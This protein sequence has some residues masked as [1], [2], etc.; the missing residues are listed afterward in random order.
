[1]CDSKIPINFDHDYFILESKEFETIYNSDVQIIWGIISAVPENCK[2]NIELI[3]ELSSE[4]EKA[5]QSDKFLIS[6]SIL[7]IVAFD[8]G[9]TIIKFRNLELSNK[10]KEYFGE[11]ALSLQKFN[12]KYLNRK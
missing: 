3:S 7:E 9:Y 4:D 2:F 10:F 12:E 11:E 5:W 1:M 6:E 8:S